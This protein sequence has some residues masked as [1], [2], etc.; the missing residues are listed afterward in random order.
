MRIK[1]IEPYLFLVPALFFV[2]LFLI[3]PIVDT[4]RNSFG[5]VDLINGFMNWIGF[6]NYKLLFTPEFMGILAKTLIW[7]IGSMI[8]VIIFGV[9]I[10][11]LL[12]KPF[13]G[14]KWVRVLVIVPWLIPEAFAATMWL[15]VLNT[16][17]GFLNNI[18]LSLGIID[19]SIGFLSASTAMFTVIL[20]RVWKATPFIIMTTL[21]ALQTI[22]K[23]VEEAA[24]LEGATGWKYV[25]HIVL[26]H[27][28]IV[29][30]VSI[31]ILTTW[32]LK[33]FDTIFIMTGGGPM[34]AT[35]TIS[36][37]IYNSA[38]LGLDLGSASVMAIVTVLMVL[39]MSIY[40]F[41]KQEED[42]M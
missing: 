33:I 41:K 24:I 34:K 10:A 9:L 17:Y 8:P 12:N 4:I 1:R 38:F 25:Y 6:E 32:T 11:L 31:V 20:V 23:D 39:L 42:L 36:I 18:L 19:E 2:V 35:E 16:E 40:I 13:P 7:V 37:A 22:P 5:K 3:L 14:V 26:P 30:P 27:L 21:A 29:L 15:W 28:K